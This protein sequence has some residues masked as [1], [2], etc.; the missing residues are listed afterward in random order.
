MEE[1]RDLENI[2]PFEE[3]ETVEVNGENFTLTSK[4]KVKSITDPL[5]FPATYSWY[6]AE[7]ENNEEVNIFFFDED[8]DS[9]EE[10]NLVAEKWWKESY[11]NL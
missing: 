5:G 2:Y 10:N 7:T 8:F 4:V 6:K 3:G 11:R 9:V 1:D